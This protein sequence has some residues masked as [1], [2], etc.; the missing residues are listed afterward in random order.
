MLQIGITGGMGTG[1]STVCKIFQSL[2][3]PVLNTDELAKQLYLSNAFLQQKIKDAFGENTFDN[4]ILN[5]KLLAARAFSSAEKTT[6]LNRIVHPFVFAA[7][8][9]W[10]RHQNS[11]YAIRESAL[12]IES[13]NYTKLD[14]IIGVTSA[15][16]VRLH[17]IIVR[18]KCSTQEA[19][20]RINK[21]MPDEL[22]SKFYH[23]TI[24]NEPDKLLLPQVMQ[25][26]QQLLA[27]C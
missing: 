26:H 21:Q 1:K 15:M 24:T 8:E 19:I 25:I 23:F 4:N 14:Y 13:S 22:K 3:V 18:D 7:I 16:P 6:L 10:Q 9:D 20:D 5:K 11:K 2:G 27:L 17:R 12:L